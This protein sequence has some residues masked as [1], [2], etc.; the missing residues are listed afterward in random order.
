MMFNEV[1]KKVDLDRS[2]RSPEPLSPPLPARRIHSFRL[3]S[4]ILSLLTPEPFTP[5]RLVTMLPCPRSKG[6][7]TQARLASG[8][9]VLGLVLPPVSAFGQETSADAPTPPPSTSPMPPQMR[10]PSS[11]PSTPLNPDDFP[12]FDKVTEGYEKVV[13]T[14]DGKPS[15][16]TL[17]VRQRDGQMLAELPRNFASQKHFVA[18][19]V[20]SG[21]TYAGLQA[22]DMYVYWKQYDKRL[23]LIQPNVEVRSTGD[24]ESKSS[25]QRLFTDRVI[26][27]VPIVTMV[28]RGGPMI[29]LDEL[30][31]GRAAD[32]FGPAYRPSNPRLVTVKTAKAFPE[33]VEVGLE[34]PTADGT[35]KILHYSIS[36]IPDSTGYQ[37]R[38]ADERVGFFT[39]AYSDLGKFEDG[40]DRVRYIN[41]WFLEKADPSLKLSPPKQPIVFYI[42]HTTPIR[43]RRF[44]RDGVLYWNKAFEKVGIANAIEVYY[45]DEASGQHME[46]DPEDVRYNFI[47]WLNNNVGTAIGPSRVNPMTGQILDADIV[48]TDGWIRHFWKQ[49][50]Q[51]LPK[52]AMDGFSPETLAWLDSRPQ[53]DPRVRMADPVERQNVLNERA[54]RAMQPYGGHPIA[55]E[56]SQLMGSSEFDG[57]VGRTSQMNG[58][59]MASI[60]KAMDVATMQLHFAATEGDEPKKDGEKKDEE[61]KDG[62]KKDGEKKD[63]EKKEEAKNLLDGIPEEFIGPMIA[64]LVAHECGHTLG[65]RHNF[66]ASG[67]YTLAEINSDTVKGKKPYTGSVM[68][69]NPV[70]INME[71]GPVQGDWTMIDI[72]P[73]DRWVIEYG[74]TFDKDL[75]PILA[76]VAE[77]ELAY[78]TD[79]DTGG[80]DPLARRY[81]FSKNPLDYAK[82]QMRLAKYHRERLLDKFVKDGESWDKARRGYEMTLSY[83][84]K[85]LGMMSGWVGGS[86]IHRDRKG[87]KDGRNPV[88]PIAAATQREALK[89]LID[90]SF[91]DA[92][93]GITPELLSRMTVDKWMDG[94][95][96][97]RGAMAEPAW[98]I[99]DRIMGIQASTL[100]MLLN[101]TTLRRVYDNEFR[102]PSDQDALTLPELLDTI[103]CSVWGELDKPAEGTFTARK[104]MISSLRRNLQREHVERLIDLGMPGNVSGAAAKPIANLSQSQL[105]DLES[106]IGK[107]LEA[108]AAKLDPYTKAHLAETRELIKRAL[109][110]QVIYNTDDLARPSS[111]GM[112]I[113]L[114]ESPA[115]K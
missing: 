30:L 65:L 86:D 87:D 104:P 77:P 89:F 115:G 56:R 21:E 12:P 40:K 88:Q 109:D 67:L 64:D 99:H 57:L 54:V 19:T 100:T 2:R 101:P 9:L 33:N 103:S 107:A 46:K 70:N 85:A 61:K 7:A 74:Y 72:G 44:V 34:V 32:F 51:E 58:L 23:A 39:T 45:Q 14:V 53:W 26:L 78:A 111:G 28:P 114:G 106:K 55:A 108:Q 11:G 43:Y 79:E 52:L 93:F 36:L 16:Y 17:W 62:E 49:F 92:S 22:G 27:D 90:N 91:D 97:I 110:A 94:D 35:L 71:C 3:V 47:R 13:S 15:F 5:M 29:D 95:D 105:R 82:E 6:R 48:L 24:K 60:G 25:V 98:P 41:R 63:G 96:G 76:R 102:I 1:E 113:R 75:K 4:P 8:L 18:M 50:N 84:T 59:C 42:E 69:Y 37:A 20:A 31:V 66:K 83:Q 10:G 68:D 81:D 73:Y 38:E 112:I 80:P